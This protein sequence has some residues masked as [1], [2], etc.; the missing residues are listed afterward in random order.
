MSTLKLLSYSIL[1]TARRL[2]AFSKSNDKNLMCD[3][4]VIPLN[5]DYRCALR[6]RLAEFINI[7]QVDPFKNET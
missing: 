7:D 3:I 6:K 5:K 2:F 1:S 4:K